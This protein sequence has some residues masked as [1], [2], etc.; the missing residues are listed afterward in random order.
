MKSWMTLLVVGACACATPLLADRASLHRWDANFEVQE[1]E[2]VQRSF[3][4]TGAAP[5][6]LSVDNMT[7]P[8]RVAAT[9][10]KNVE[11]SVTKVIAARSA[12]FVAAARK[13]VTLEINESPTGVDLY[14]DGPFRCHCDGCGC[15]T[16]ARSSEDC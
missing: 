12:D 1:T 13:E 6:R 4:L 14:V 9:D 10:Q 5:W 8:I 16:T 7:G 11:L 2:E 3:T 15:R